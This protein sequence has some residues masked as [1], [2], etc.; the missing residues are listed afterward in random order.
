MQGPANGG[1]ADEGCAAECRVS[2]RGA[3]GEVMMVVAEEEG[4]GG[5]AGR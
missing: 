2:V 3:A 5:G 1:G 4:G